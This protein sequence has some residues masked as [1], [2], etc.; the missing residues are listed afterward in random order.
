MASPVGATLMLPDEVV[1]LA[2]G[3]AAVVAWTAVSI[4]SQTGTQTAKA[5]V[6]KVRAK[7]LNPVVMGVASTATVSIR[8]S[9]TNPTTPR[10]VLASPGT[11]ASD[12][13]SVERTVVVPVDENEEFDYKVVEGG[14]GSISWSISLEGWYL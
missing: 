12:S 5:A 7:A 11:I 13:D 6:L 2:S 9:G 1:S 10:S 8:E 14:T 3:V 4:A